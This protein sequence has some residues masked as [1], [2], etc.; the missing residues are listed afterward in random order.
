MF[1]TMAD[2][3]VS[4]F[5]PQMLKLRQDLQDECVVSESQTTGQDMGLSMG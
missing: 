1:F 4:I 3:A 2:V 5:D